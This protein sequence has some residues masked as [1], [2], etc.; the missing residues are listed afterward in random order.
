MALGA[1][2]LSHPSGDGAFLPRDS[3][4]GDLHG[5]RKQP[6]AHQIVNRAAREAGQ[7]LNLAAAVVFLDHIRSPFHDGPWRKDR[8]KLGFAHGATKKYFLS[9][10]LP[11][12]DG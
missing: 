9:R 3:F 2:P 5:A 8:E 7:G 12:V 11:E 4:A 10:T 1:P 6:L